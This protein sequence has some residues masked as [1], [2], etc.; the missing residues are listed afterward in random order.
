MKK[1][2]GIILGVSLIIPAMSQ[3]ADQKKPVNNWT[4]E[5]FLDI[6]STF[7]P[8]AVGF[9]EALNNKDKP[10]DAVLDVDGIQTLTPLV[11]QACEADKTAS[12]KK[13]VD[14]VKNTHKH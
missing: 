8:V 7:Q 12:F 13:T 1:V 11:I 3:A 14:S 10:E 9:S 2:L 5:E 4:C 6:D